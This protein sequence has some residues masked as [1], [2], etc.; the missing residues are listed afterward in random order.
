MGNGGPCGASCDALVDAVAAD[1]HAAGLKRV[2]L[3]SPRSGTQL[4]GRSFIVKR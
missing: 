2:E 4:I 1:P 3:V